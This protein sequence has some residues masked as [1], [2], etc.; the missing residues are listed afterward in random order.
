M[1]KRAGG[2]P[3]ADRSGPVFLAL[4]RRLRHPG[5]SSFAGLV[6]PAC[7]AGQGRSA[8]VAPARPLR[9]PGDVFEKKTRKG[10]GGMPGPQSSN[11]SFPCISSRSTRAR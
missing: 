7:P 3:V 5:P 2:G 10:T 1:K 8:A 11:R 4:N 9:G 6:S